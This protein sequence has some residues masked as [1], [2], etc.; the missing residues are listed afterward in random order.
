MCVHD[1]NLGFAS[2]S[3]NVDAGTTFETMPLPAKIGQPP[4]SVL[5]VDDEAELLEPHRLFL[6][7]KGY[8]VAVATNADD[9]VEML[10]RRPYD[11]LLLDEQ[12][13]GKR[14]LEAYREVRE[15][16]PT[17]PVVMV[18][19]SEDDATLREALGTEV[20]DYLVKPVNPRQVLSVVTRILEGPK[21]RQQ[22]VARAFVDR[23]RAI[24]LERERSLHWRGWIERFDE[25]VRWDL[26][27]VD[28]DRIARIAAWSVPRHA[29]R[30][31]VVHAP[32]LS[33]VA[34][35]PRG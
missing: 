1:R 3:A 20:S 13:P 33:P 4:K 29:S 2:H 7:D 22:A 18:T 5:W 15:I 28:A 31:R 8:D 24:E 12:M 27:L 17:L 23:F 6:A 10:R 30:V 16:A 11:L 34:A 21:L 14:G 26:D 9:A 32:R 25:L 19:K 35:Q